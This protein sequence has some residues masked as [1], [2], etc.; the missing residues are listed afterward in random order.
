MNTK[1]ILIYYFSGSGNT[2]CVSNLFLKEFENHGVQT[3]VIA[4]EDVLNRKY[5]FLSNDI[6][7]I[8]FGHPVH[9]FGAPRIFIDFIKSIPAIENIPSFYFRTAGDPFCQAGSTSIV[10]KT[11]QNKGYNIFHES[12]LVM[13]ANV[14]YQYNDDIIKQLYIT[15]KRK[16]SII[17]RQVLRN[18]PNLQKNS[19]LLKTISY[20]FNKLETLGA[21]YF[22]KTLYVTDSCNH[23]RLCVKKC[24]TNNIHED[25]ESK[26]I[27][28]GN[29]CTFCLRCVYLC[30]FSSIRNKYMNFFIIKDGYDISKAIDN[31]KIKGDYITSATKGFFKHFYKYL[32][33]F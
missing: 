28:F 31:P 4:I 18:K 33:N 11:L 8:G 24:P 6:D 13:P 1:K 5:S 12:L 7:L 22:G 9:A 32:H 20:L 29:N 30:P 2:E 16:I 21:G 15:A 27:K 26:E 3:R 17:V 10:R 19:L 23:C 14:V 25:S